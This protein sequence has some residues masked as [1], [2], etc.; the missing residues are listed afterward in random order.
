[1]K[2]RGFTV[3]EITITIAFLLFAGILFWSQKN[4]LDVTYR[5][6]QRKTAINAMHYSL[7][8]SYFKQNKYY[9]EEINESNLTTMDATLFTDPD[10]VK[11]GQ[12]SQTVDDEE[13]PVQS[14]YRYEATN[15]SEGKCRGYTL[16]A[17]LQGEE[18][19]V[20]TNR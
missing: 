2:Q 17:D 15:C 20:K 19:F 9:P 18:D 12:T 13:V 7:E 1:M 5:D 3:V 14:N 4:N 8:E 10:G 16:R 11:L 6:T